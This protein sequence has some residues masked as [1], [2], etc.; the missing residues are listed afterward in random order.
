MQRSEIAV[1][2]DDLTS[3]VRRYV[4]MAERTGG[5]F[6][7]ER[8]ELFGNTH[9]G[10]SV[11]ALADTGIYRRSG[12]RLRFFSG[13]AHTGRPV[14]NL[15]ASSGGTGN[16]WN[17]A[18]ES[19]PIMISGTHAAHSMQ[20]F[21]L[22]ECEKKR[23]AG[24]LSHSASHALGHALFGSWPAVILSVLFQRKRSLDSLK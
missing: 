13:H 21:H 14:Y 22:V 7:C 12:R 23:Q 6:V 10:L 19:S 2:C 4:R 16:R 20:F 8:A 1:G 9:N 11:A 3:A 24:I 17:E 18:N 15:D 5:A